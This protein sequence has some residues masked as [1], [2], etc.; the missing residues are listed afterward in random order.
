MLFQQKQN[1]D[2]IISNVK[3]HVNISTHKNILDY[4]HHYI[5]NL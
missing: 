4:V 3:F 2:N 1:K 5:L